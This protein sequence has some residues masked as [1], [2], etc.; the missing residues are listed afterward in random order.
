[1]FSLLRYARKRRPTR[2]FASV[3]LPRKRKS[4]KAARNGTFFIASTTRKS[5]AEWALPPLPTNAVRPPDRVSWPRLEKNRKVF[6][7]KIE[8]AA[9]PPLSSPKI[10]DRPSRTLISRKITVENRG[11]AS[12]WADRRHYR[13]DPAVLYPFAVVPFECAVSAFRLPCPA[14]CART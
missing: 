4:S 7:K 5:F 12:T 6:D 10:F 11:A 9:W 2:K 1:K 14:P 8:A 3:S 13:W